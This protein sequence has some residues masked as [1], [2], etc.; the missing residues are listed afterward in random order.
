MI[1]IWPCFSTSHTILDGVMCAEINPSHTRNNVICIFSHD[2]ITWLIIFNLI[3]N[4][5]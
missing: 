2:N 1:C 3:Q 5:S 4:I